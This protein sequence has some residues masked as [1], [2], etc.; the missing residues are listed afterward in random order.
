MSKIQTPTVE[1]GWADLDLV[2]ESVTIAQGF[3][4]ER[5]REIESSPDQFGTECDLPQALDR[6]AQ[7][8]TLIPRLRAELHRLQD[9]MEE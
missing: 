7:F 9:A 2:Y 1:I 3:W 8:K 4:Q 6:I 5:V